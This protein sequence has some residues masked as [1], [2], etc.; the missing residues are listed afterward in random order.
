M[1]L[2]KRAAI[3]GSNIPGEKA[4]KAIAGIKI[5]LILIRFLTLF[6]KPHDMEQHTYNPSNTIKLGS[7][8]MIWFLPH[9]VS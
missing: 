6:F 5:A 2:V 7:S 4:A 8:R 1:L 9:P 3:S